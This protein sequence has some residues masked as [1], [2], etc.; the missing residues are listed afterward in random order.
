MADKKIQYAWFVYKDDADILWSV[1]L[2][3]RAGVI[4]NFESPDPEELP[5]SPAH[6]SVWGWQNLDMRHVT[7]K[8]EAGKYLKF[9]CMR[10]SSETYN[11][12]GQEIEV[13]LWDTGIDD[14]EPPSET[15]SGII[16][17]RTGERPRK[18][19]YRTP[20]STPA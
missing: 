1:T 8:T 20:Y 14:G 11:A 13:P 2:R 7:V 6:I 9:P 12:V 18:G 15:I 16:V 5:V 17:S 4:G 19:P 3:K 10:V